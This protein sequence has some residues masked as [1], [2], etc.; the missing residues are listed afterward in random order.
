M[1]EKPAEE[2]LGALAVQRGL[3]TIEQ[4][5]EAV[6]EQE[7]RTAAGGQVPLGEILIE[8]EFIGRKQL[9]AL[10]T[11]QGK[12]PDKNQPIEGFELLKK[13][14][15]GGMGA[16]YLARQESMDRLVA[17]KVLNESLSRNEEFVER[18]VREARLAGRMNHVNMVQCQDVG[19]CG[20]FHYLV[21]EYVE[22]KG[23]GSM[24]PEGGAVAEDLSLHICTQV[25]RALD[26]AHGNDIVH[27]DVKPD[28]I[29]VTE[30]GV[31]KLCDFGLARDT[32][33]DARLT[34]TG[35][36]MGTPHYVS[37]EQARGDREVD[38]RSDIYSL[39]A[40]LYHMV[41]GQ[42]PFGGDSAMAVVTKHLT[43]KLAWPR[44]VNP[45]VS[46]A[47]CQ[48]ISR[49]MAKDPKDRYQT[50]AELLKDLELVSD[51]KG[52]RGGSLDPSLTSVAGRAVAA[53]AAEPTMRFGP[54]SGKEAGPPGV[55]DSAAE[56]T[57]VSDRGSTEGGAAPAGAPA[58]P[59]AEAA[60]E[61]EPEPPAPA[62]VAEKPAEAE[63]PPKK[64]L[65]R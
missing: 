55:P 37:P 58:A 59:P 20:D 12:A 13:L 41:T 42:P 65:P 64:T 23:A 51:G 27:R 2:Q 1:P 57:M 62:A 16:T 33:Q 47:C 43:E 34:Q 21:M 38:I 19:R 46:E 40:T 35:M 63:K 49:M 54:G 24:I 26:F 15:E 60:A 22:G 9:D 53:A 29:L 5:T 31:A 48:L 39:G 17:L 56:P 4:L 52:P 14:G 30:A 50:P 32:G 25:A 10:L 7:R 18:F 45:A 28:N 61:R 11:A 3:L 8:M 36:M 6:R 44:D